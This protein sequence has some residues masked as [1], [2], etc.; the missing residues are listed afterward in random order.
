MDDVSVPTYVAVRDA[1][2]DAR[3]AEHQK[4]QGKRDRTPDS[5]FKPR[6]SARKHQ[7]KKK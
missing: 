7:P 6:K 4:E 3:N 2:I 5:P 1:F